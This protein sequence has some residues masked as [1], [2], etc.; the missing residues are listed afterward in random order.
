MK[1]LFSRLIWIPLLLVAVL[2]ALANKQRV[3]LSFDPFPV[4]TPFLQTVALPLWSWFILFFLLGYVVGAGALWVSG[5][6][7]RR[8]AGAVKQELKKLRKEKEL[9]EASAQQGGG[10]GA[11]D[12]LPVLKAS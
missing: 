2:F 5:R 11:G 10:A 3:A 4:E 7:K 8:Q 9:T 12:N 1:K 6:D